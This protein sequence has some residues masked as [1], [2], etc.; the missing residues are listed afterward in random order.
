MVLD[1]LGYG[2]RMSRFM[3]EPLN[4]VGDLSAWFRLRTAADSLESEELPAATPSPA[5]AASPRA[6]ATL[7]CDGEGA[8][9]PSS[10]KL[11]RSASAA[12]LLDVASSA[13]Q[14]KQC[15]FARAID[16]GGT[17]KERQSATCEG[18]RP[19]PFSRES[20]FQTEVR[21]GSAQ[22][23]RKSAAGKQGSRRNMVASTFA[24][25]S[26][27]KLPQSRGA[28]QAQPL[29]K[30]NHDGELERMLDALRASGR[31]YTEEDE[32]S[33]SLSF[34]ELCTELV[35]E[36]C[37][38]LEEH[39]PQTRD[40]AA[41]LLRARRSGAVKYVM[42]D[43]DE[44]DD[45]GADEDDGR[46]DAHKLL[47]PGDENDNYVTVTRREALIQPRAAWHGIQEHEAGVSFATKQLDLDAVSASLGAR[48]RSSSFESSFTARDVDQQTR[49]EWRNKVTS[50]P[51]RM[52][53][54]R[55]NAGDSADAGSSRLPRPWMPNERRQAVTSCPVPGAAAQPAGRRASTLE[56]RQVRRGTVLAQPSPLPA[57][58]ADMSVTQDSSCVQRRGSVAATCAP[59][60]RSGS[61][62]SGLRQ[63][64]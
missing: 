14:R 45:T 54:S 13:G 60:P 1:D 25:S 28:S 32:I 6:S 8:Q 11:E 20:S 47:Q 48:R 34:V 15:T 64:V 5:E 29:E 53:G 57:P 31:T 52:A 41:T 37:S 2:D 44:D 39:T 46:A 43:E 61:V 62:A 16:M 18:K 55:G 36:D 59:R 35:G 33:Y 24:F 21:R 4:R 38:T 7:A 42:D 51:G 10:G 12:C 40:V 22:E 26:E 3:S 27:L 17:F 49:S 63:R 23:S 56:V 58:P 19:A 9:R 30:G 50:S